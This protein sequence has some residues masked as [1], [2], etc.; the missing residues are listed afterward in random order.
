VIGVAVIGAGHWGPNLIRNFHDHPQSEVLWVIER[1]PARLAEVHVRFPSV[2]L[3]SEPAEAFHD[4]RVAA[5]VVA[6]AGSRSVVSSLW[7][8]EDSAT[9]LLMEDFYKNLWERRLPKAEAL[10]QAQLAVLNAPGRIRG[11]SV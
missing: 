2:R 7:K 10:R 4:P 9:S 5:V 8:V 3:S 11:S 1:D 6:T